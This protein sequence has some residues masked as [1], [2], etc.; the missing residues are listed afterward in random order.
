MLD[1]EIKSEAVILKDWRRLNGI[2]TE[3]MDAEKIEEFIALAD[4]L[5]RRDLAKSLC[6]FLSSQGVQLFPIEI[7]G[8]LIEAVEY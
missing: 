2:E 1:N 8:D 5:G 3:E 6:E 7:M 4:R